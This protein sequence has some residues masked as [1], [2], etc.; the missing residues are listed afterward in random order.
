MKEIK[1]NKSFVV[2]VCI[3]SVLVIALGCFVLYSKVFSKSES[4]NKESVNT[5]NDKINITIEKNTSSGYYD[6]L[7]INGKTIKAKN[8]TFDSVIFLDDSY[9]ITAYRSNTEGLLRYYVY[10]KNGD[11]LYNINELSSLKDASTIELNYVVGELNIQTVT[12]LTGDNY[13]SL[14]SLDQ[15]AVYTKFETIKYSGNGKFEKAKTLSSLTV[16]DYLKNN[17]NYTCN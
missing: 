12:T 9:I 5:S 13:R 1:S 15:S 3:L 2:I 11:R 4:N 8:E 7:V 16:K 10:D 17:Y 6:Q 14:C